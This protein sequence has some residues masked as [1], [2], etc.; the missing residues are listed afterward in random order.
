MSKPLLAIVAKIKSDLLP[1][2]LSQVIPLFE[3]KGWKFTSDPALLESWQKAEI[4]STLETHSSRSEVPTLCLCLGGDGTLLS[5]AREFGSRGVPIVSINL[6]SL[7]FIASNAAPQ[8]R[9]LIDHYFEK[10]LVS[11]NRHTL[12]VKLFRSQNLIA[13]GIVLNDVVISKGSLARMI[14]MDLSVQ[15]SEI[16]T[17]RADGLV[18]STPTGS[19]AYSFSTGGPIVQP[20]L[21]ACLLAPIC[22]HSP[23]WRPIVLK[24]ETMVKVGLQSSDEAFLTLDGQVGYPLLTSDFVIVE[25][26]ELKIT[27]LQEPDLNYFT[28]LREKLNWASR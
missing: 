23:S 22:P 21:D 15:G 16:G 26:S 12:G 2:V 6:G 5:A 9:L 17:L 24:G 25:K 20:E 3:S 4:H 11:D 14:E 13:E 10:K 28:L 8:A 19:T 7:G 1:Q 27:L 18:I